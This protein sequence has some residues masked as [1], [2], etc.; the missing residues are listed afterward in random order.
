MAPT[1]PTWQQDFDEIAYELNLPQRQ[2]EAAVKLKGTPT[3]YYEVRVTVGG[4]SLIMRHG[5]GDEEDKEENGRRRRL[6][7][8]RESEGNMKVR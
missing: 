3:S 2:R 4:C 7:G 5:G 1:L 6:A 8:M